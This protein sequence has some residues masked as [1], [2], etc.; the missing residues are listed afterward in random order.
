MQKS[1]SENNYTSWN[2]RALIKSTAVFFLY[3]MARTE[4]DWSLH[5][6]L[7][8]VYCPHDKLKNSSTWRGIHAVNI[9]QKQNI[10]LNIL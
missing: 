4:L 2:F 3:D 10:C 6:T 9:M 1:L 8:T 7:R 5:S